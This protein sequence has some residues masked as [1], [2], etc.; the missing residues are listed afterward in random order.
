MA[1]A[2]GID[3]GTTYSCVGVF[4]DDRIEII[5]NDQGNRT[6]PSF[7]AF[8]DTE[9]L[10]GDAAKNQV[11]MN[12]H[13]TVFDAK[14]LIGR[15][16][17]DAEVQSDMKHW[18][19]KVVEKGGKPIIEVEFKGETKQFTPEEI[20]SMVLTKMRE[21]AE[22]YLGG[23]VNNAVIT[24]PAYF[25]DSQR[26]ATKDAGLIAGLNVLRIINEPTAAAIAYG[27]DKKAEGERN[28]LIFDL[29]GG[30]FDVSLLTIEEGIFEVKATAGDTHLG[31]EDFD[32]RLV[33][34]F[35]NEFKRKHRKDLTTNARALRRLRTACE[36]AKRTLSSAA[37]T[38]IEIDS[39]FEG[40]DFYT[41]IT[42]ARFEELCQDLFRSTMEPVERVLRDAKIDKSSVHEIVLVG[43]STRIPK[44]QRLVADFFNKEANKSIN[45]DEAVAYGAAVQAAIL[46]G[47]T[48]S[49]S[50]NEILLLD[51]APLS[52]GIETAGG[53]MT[54][55]IK[56]NTTIPTKKSETFS[57]YSD[58][59]PGVLIQ[60]YEG[61]RAR[62]KDNNLLGKF[63]LTG[64]PPAPRGVP[65]IEVTFDV[66]ANGIMNV[67]AVEKGTGKTNK[68]TIT[69]D[70]GR[71]SKEE[72]ERMLADAEK[73]KEE[74]EA[75]AA[76]IQAKNGLESYAYSL[77]NT[78]SEGKLNISDADKEK[79]SS[80]VEEIISWLDNNQTAT[81][82]EY[83]SQQKELESVANPI[84]SAAYG[85][86]AGAAPGGAAPGGATRTAD[87]VEE[88]PE[89]LD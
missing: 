31:G 82:D 19:F 4:R 33:N 8:T 26:Q 24:V 88:R 55:L 65:Q 30:T 35:V 71:L 20:S 3:L 43:G 63:E 38:S 58:N 10:I 69:N 12:P 1:P 67:S 52:L 34:H 25:N 46:S 68:I 18:P 9:R 50:T 22:A 62:T 83:E 5:A 81:K 76:R 14:R 79:V 28:V 32:N 66:D 70:K 60:V 42:R 48:S 84:I 7:V 45:P 13:N 29:G 39:L 64:I 47:D 15:R 36:R 6:T 37:Q 27:L 44:I 17:Q 77:K 78:I 54:P 72:I 73:Y 59:Q 2:V 49:K 40:I 61:E 11:A 56:R 75:E 53:V 51:V 16:F 21:T 80:K 74:D 86:A 89:E 23:T 57:T 87:E 85:G 41:S